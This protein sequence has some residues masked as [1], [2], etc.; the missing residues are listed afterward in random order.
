MLRSARQTA[1]DPSTGQRATCVRN[2]RNRSPWVLRKSNASRQLKEK[3]LSKIVPENLWRLYESTPHVVPKT[4]GVEVGR[5]SSANAPSTC[6]ADNAPC[7]SDAE[8]GAP[9]NA[10]S[11]TSCAAGRC[12]QTRYFRSALGAWLF[13]ATA[14]PKHRTR[15][16]H[17][18]GPRKPQ[19]REPETKAAATKERK[20]ENTQ[21]EE[22]KKSARQ[23]LTTR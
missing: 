19:P 15:V 23:P 16:R 9:V 10:W 13:V 5:M 22:H 7:A 1:R 6:S 11:T 2:G 4:R 21:R 3:K 18:K 17:L 14:A 8:Q 20:S 12:F